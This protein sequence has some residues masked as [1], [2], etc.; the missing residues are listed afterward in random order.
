MTKKISFTCPHC[1]STFE[2]NVKEEFFGRTILVKCAKCSHQFKNVLPKLDEE[3]SADET[4]ING[5]NGFKCLKLEVLGDDNTK[6]QSFMINQEYTVIGRKNTS[7]PEYRPDVGIETNDGYMSRKHCVI[8]RTPKGQFTIKDNGAK[9][10]TWL[11]GKS[12][13]EVE[14][15]YLNDGDDIRIGHTHIKVTLMMMDSGNGG[16]AKHNSDEETYF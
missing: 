2:L 12:L 13:S 5:S 4:Y 9:N 1:S 10:R 6:P 3:G 14:K 11:N 16:G 8:Q 15:L 7:G